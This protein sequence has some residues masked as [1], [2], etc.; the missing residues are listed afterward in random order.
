[1]LVKKLLPFIVAVALL[2]C[3]EGTA[4]SGAEIDLTLTQ[5]DGKPLP[6]TVGVLTTGAAATVVGSGSL[7]GNDIGPDCKITLTVNTGDPLV[8]DILPCTINNG[9]VIDYPIDL[10]NNTSAHLY[11]FQ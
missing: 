2:S 8:F 6:F 4:P 10:G 7:V 1:M 5:V 9:D 11:R 3:T